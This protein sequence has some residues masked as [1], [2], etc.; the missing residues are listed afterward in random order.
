M[1]P[2]VIDSYSPFKGTAYGCMLDELLRAHRIN[3]LYIGGLAT[4]YCVKE[5]V[6][7]ACRSKYKTYLLTDACQAVNIKPGDEALALNEMAN[8]GAQFITTREVILQSR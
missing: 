1:D 2:N 4:D 5:A 7:D 3:K 8:A 6:L